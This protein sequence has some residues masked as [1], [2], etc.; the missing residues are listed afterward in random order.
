MASGSRDTGGESDW[1]LAKEGLKLLINNKTKEAEDLFMK[2]PE[3]LVMYSGYS[4]AVFMVS[5]TSVCLIFSL[6]FRSESRQLFLEEFFMYPLV[7]VGIA[8]VR[9]GG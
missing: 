2:Y 3:S 5:I 9:K 7:L 1:I 4:F 8:D 6:Q